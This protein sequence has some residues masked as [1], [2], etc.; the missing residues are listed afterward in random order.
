MFDELPEFPGP[1]NLALG[2][3]FR[4]NFC[5]FFAG[6][7]LGHVPDGTDHSAFPLAIGVPHADPATTLLS[8][9]S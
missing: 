1:V 4:D 3:F 9:T 5:N 6:F 2:S 8:D 7:A